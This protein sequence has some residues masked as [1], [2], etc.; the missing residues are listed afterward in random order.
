MSKIGW[1]QLILVGPTGQSAHALEAAESQEV[2]FHALQFN[3]LV[4][5]E[6]DDWAQPGQLLRRCVNRP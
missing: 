2:V 5:K 1:L 6:G 4:T 3:A